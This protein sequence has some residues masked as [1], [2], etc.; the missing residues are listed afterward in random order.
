[1]IA[2]HRSIAWINAKRITVVAVVEQID[3][4]AK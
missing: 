3:L 1:M 4:A 2:Y